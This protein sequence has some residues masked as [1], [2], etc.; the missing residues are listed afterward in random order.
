[1]EDRRLDGLVLDALHRLHR[2]EFLLGVNLNPPNP[3]PAVAAFLSKAHELVAGVEN[4]VHGLLGATF[5]DE[6]AWEAIRK[7]TGQERGC[8]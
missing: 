4:E 2:L 1:M 7:A 3:D 6:A 5:G 8:P